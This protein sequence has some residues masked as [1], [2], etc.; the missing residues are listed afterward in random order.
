MW[1][2]V[3]L[4]EIMTVIFTVI[5]YSERHQRVFH[6]IT[7]RSPHAIWMMTPQCHQL[8]SPLN[9]VF[10]CAAYI[11]TCTVKYSN[12]LVWSG[13]TLDQACNHHAAGAARRVSSTRM[14]SSKWIKQH[15]AWPRLCEARCRS[16]NVSQMQRCIGT[17]SKF[18]CLEFG[19]CVLL[20]F[21][22]FDDIYLRNDTSF[23]EIALVDVVCH[24]NKP[25]R[26]Q[27]PACYSLSF[28]SFSS[29][30]WR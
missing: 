5:I 19:S 22:D 8:V 14:H 15:S 25:Y 2:S 20:Q 1:R 10:A 30:K 7:L 17:L 13:F 29:R 21:T 28:L 6:V 16:E 3:G 11:C 4:I 9:T 24:A 18:D 27:C 26:P 12:I 23:R